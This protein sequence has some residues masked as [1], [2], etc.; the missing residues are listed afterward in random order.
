MAAT[1]LA[2]TVAAVVAVVVA[3]SG[4]EPAVTAGAQRATSTARVQ[5][6]PLS[7]TV[8]LAG[9]LTYAAR[10]DGSPYA[11]IDQASGTYTELP[12]IGQV[13]PQGQALYRVDGSPVV[14]LY[15]AMP[16]YRALA[17]G[18]TGADVGQLNADLVALG[19]ATRAELNP[20]STSYGAATAMA[21]AKLQAASALTPTGALSLGEVL[22]EPTALR[23]IAVPAQPGARAQVG[24][25]VLQAT[26]SERQVQVALDASQQ[27]EM[28]VGDKVSI[29][30][31]DNR[32]TPGV[33]TSVGSVATC[34]GVTPPGSS[35]PVSPASGTDVCASATTGGAT[36]TIAVVI[37]PSDPSATGTWDQAPV[38][39]AITTA[40]VPNAL[41]VP[42][43][44]LLARS[45]GGYAVEVIR[46]GGA[47]HLVP[48]SL[49]LFDD[50]AGLVQVTGSRLAAGQKVVVPAI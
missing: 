48:V 32:T 49:G 20:A 30:L 7:A 28:A 8:S 21:V 25:I 6:G 12:A 42:V 24:Q 2:S 35:T 18:M 47:R 16:A 9:A 22:F 36:P 31:P 15:G 1:A 37:T 50:A 33:V 4:P 46:T 11:V 44:A 19:Y 23:V 39:V 10:A 3:T 41:A 5:E 13:V 38:R 40:R 26:S 43:T 34:A 29:V 14:L 27:T 17:P 45:E